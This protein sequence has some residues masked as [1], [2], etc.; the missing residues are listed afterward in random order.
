MKFTKDIRH[1]LGAAGIFL[2][3]VGLLLFLSFFEVPA[4]NKDIFVSIVGMIAATLSVVIYTLIGRNPEE[5][6]ELKKKVEGMQATLD[7][8]EARNDQLEAIIIKTQENTID[9]LSIIGEGFIKDLLD[10]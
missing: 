7:S 4:D 6:T 3:M 9:K 5:V 1:Y 8:M 2:L 10:K